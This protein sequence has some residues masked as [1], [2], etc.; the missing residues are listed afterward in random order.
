MKDY[1][2]L[3]IDNPV[4]SGFSYAESTSAFAVD[5]AQIASDLLQLMHGFYKKLP[6]FRDVPVY[7]TS[8]SYGGKMA[9]E[10]A[11]LWYKAEKSGTIDSKL[12]GVG[13]GDSWI[14][15]L[16]SVLTW[17][18]FL[19]QTVSRFSTWTSCHI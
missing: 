19:L 14:S 13:L 12:R 15:P 1:N 18:P 9:A 6:Q 16:D 8:E 2:V 3:F 10:F 17:A 7:I 11:L 4:G 5:N